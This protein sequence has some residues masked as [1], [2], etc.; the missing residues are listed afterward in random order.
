MA[1]EGGLETGRE[2]LARWPEWFGFGPPVHVTN[3][4]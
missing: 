4:A 2:G 3:G 1:A